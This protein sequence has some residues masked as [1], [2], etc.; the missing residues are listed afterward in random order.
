MFKGRNLK[1]NVTQKWKIKEILR[2]FVKKLKKI[3][4]KN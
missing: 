2:N 1:K 3:F 4:M